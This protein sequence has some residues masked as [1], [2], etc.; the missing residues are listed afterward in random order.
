MN[1]KM[2]PIMMILVLA[3]STLACSVTFNLPDAIKG[4]GNVEQ[5]SREI[6]GFEK[7]VLR[8][9]GNVYVEFGEEEALEISAEENLLEH[10]ETY[11]K[12]DVLIIEIE[13]DK[14]I[15]PTEPIDYFITAVELNAVEVSGLADVQLP[16]IEANSFNVEI[17]GS[18]DIDIESLNAE[19]F[20]A[21]LSGLG[22]LSVDGGQV[23]SQSVE[24]SGSGSYDSHRMDSEEAEIRISGLGSA[25]LSVTDYLKV[26]ISGGGDVNYYGNPEVDSDISGLGDLDHMGD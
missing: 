19:R 11:T 4:N 5:E 21:D 8:G 1:K 12:G 26:R 20:E 14:N 17:S 6:S 13:R 7:I 9:I 16:D 25:T 23:I 2:I 22:S 18:G 15:V 3:L 10:I 24:I